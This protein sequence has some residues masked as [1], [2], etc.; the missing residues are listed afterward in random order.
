MKYTIFPTDIWE[1]L[2]V[3]QHFEGEERV[4]WHDTQVNR[5]IV[6]AGRVKSITEAEL[7]EYP[8]AWYGQTFFETVNDEAWQNMGNELV[9]FTHYYVQEEGRAYGSPP[10]RRH[11]LLNRN[12][13]S[14]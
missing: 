8:W 3:W 6:A 7:P 12:R 2:A 14:R 10:L 11:R 5:V 13:L 9:V 4:Y 1:P